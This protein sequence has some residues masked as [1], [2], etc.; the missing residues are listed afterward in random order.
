MRREQ[1]SQF[2]KLINPREMT[3]RALKLGSPGDILPA[4]QGRLCDSSAWR[5]VNQKLGGDHPCLTALHLFTEK[6]LFHHKNSQ[7]SSFPGQT[8]WRAPSLGAQPCWRHA[9]RE[10]KLAREVGGFSLRTTSPTH[11]VWGTAQRV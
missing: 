6:I 9:L 1:C 5:T 8:D 7:N 10:A 11:P 3:R 4:G 2:P